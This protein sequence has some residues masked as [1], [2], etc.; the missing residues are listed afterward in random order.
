MCKYI[1]YV[2]NILICY[3]DSFKVN[4]FTL[5]ITRFNNFKKK[6]V[7]TN[8]NINIYKSGSSKQLYVFIC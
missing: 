3:I 4:F 7:K 8:I 1:N 2:Y 6:G 5:L